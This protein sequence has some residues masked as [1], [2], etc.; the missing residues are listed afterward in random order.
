LS[1]LAHKLGIRPRICV[2]LLDVPAEVKDALEPLPSGAVVAAVSPADVVLAHCTRRA[3]VE[4]HAPEL[5]EAARMG[6][7][8][9]CAWPKQTS[10]LETDLT[11][12]EGWEPLWAAGLRGVAT[13]SIDDTWSGVRFRPAEDVRSR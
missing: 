3:D 7:I 12:D 10:G 11:R 1:S 13:V 4:R 9:W 8:V 6:A 2:L 5:I